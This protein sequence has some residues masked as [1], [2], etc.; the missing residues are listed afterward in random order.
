MKKEVKQNI[1]F[2]I[3]ILAAILL[4]AFADYIV[5]EKIYHPLSQQ[6]NI[7]WDVFSANPFGVILP[8]QWWHVAFFTIAFV[9]FALLGVAAKSWRLWLS[10][11]II[12]LTG[13]E[14][15]FYY[16]IQLKW[17]PKELSWLDAAPMGLS[18]FITQSPHVTN[19]G[20]VISA[21]IGLAVSAMIILRYNPIKLF[22]KKK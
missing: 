11:T 12:F 8:M 21:I 1:T 9:M 17:L 15:I 20:V 13:W 10:G 14:D 6:F 22:R 3:I 5:L 4:L 18:R 19:V 7:S 16:L 2:A